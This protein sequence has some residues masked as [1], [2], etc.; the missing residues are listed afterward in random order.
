MGALDLARSLVAAFPDQ[1]ARLAWQGLLRIETGDPDGGLADLISATK[2]GLAI[3]GLCLAIATAAQKQK[4]TKSAKT[5]LDQAV[6]LAPFSVKVRLARAA[7]YL[8]MRDFDAAR[9]DLAVAE[10]NGPDHP[11][12]AVL[13]QKLGQ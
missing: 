2:A 13:R 11:R 9:A 7:H 10:R 6:M 8:R 5:A 4:D 12:V 1:P 3:P